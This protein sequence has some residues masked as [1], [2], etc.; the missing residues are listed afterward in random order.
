MLHHTPASNPLEAQPHDFYPPISTGLT[1]ASEVCESIA[2]PDKPDRLL[3]VGYYVL[4]FNCLL[5]VVAFMAGSKDFDGEALPFFL[6]AAG[7]LVTQIYGINAAYGPRRERPLGLLYL[8]NRHV[9]L[10]FT[11][12]HVVIPQTCRNS[13]YR[14]V[15]LHIVATQSVG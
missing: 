12:A 7:Y 14:A 9:R 3:R 15:S 10:A 1:G 6:A 2:A 5:F 13:Y 4:G 8:A 11:G